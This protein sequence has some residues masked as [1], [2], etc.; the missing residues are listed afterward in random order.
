MPSS[1]ELLDA[2]FKAFVESAPVLCLAADRDFITFYVNPFYR[3]VHDI[4]LEEA[5]GKHIKDIIGEEG[6]NDNLKHY[7]KTLEGNIVVYDGSFIKLDGKIHH[8]RATYA[9]IYVDEEVV[10][11]TG[12][13]IDTTSEVEIVRTNK[14]L[15][16][17][18]IELERLSRV[19][20]LTDVHNRR[21][22]DEHLD[23]AWREHIRNS[24]PLS[25]MLID[26]DHFKKYNDTY[27]HQSG[28]VRWSHFVGQFDGFA[29]V[30]SAV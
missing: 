12:V 26:I 13:V 25:V 27:G 8:Y 4:T 24:L 15:K 19:D 20:G 16:N 18:T 14:E 6:F 5:K 21:Y 11:I 10:G 30:Y 22:L 1:T 23:K 17:A 3:E 9:P 28:D 29:K 2:A 7:N